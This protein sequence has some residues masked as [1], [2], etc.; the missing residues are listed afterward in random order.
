M[1]S[2][3]APPHKYIYIYIYIYIYMSSVINPHTTKTQIHEHYY[4]CNSGVV[5]EPVTGAKKW[6]L[7]IYCNP[8][9]SVKGTWRVTWRL[10][11]CRNWA[12][13]LP[14]SVKVREGSWRMTWRA[15]KRE[16][17][18]PQSVK[19]REGSV[20]ISVKG[21]WTDNRLGVA[22]TGLPVWL[23]ACVSKQ[24]PD[25]TDL[26]QWLSRPVWCK[27]QRGKDDILVVKFKRL[28]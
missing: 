1:R 2:T 4:L 5:S 24:E 26:A 3:H 23:L 14:Q 8:W 10:Q 11:I 19:V 28:I 18:L 27:S 12:M 6:C 7:L 16:L 13:I 21:Y 15:T 9:R 17:I 22:V 20:K 25:I